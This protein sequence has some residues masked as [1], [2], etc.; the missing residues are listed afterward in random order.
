M[1][2]KLISLFMVLLESVI[3]Y[4]TEEKKRGGFYRLLGTKV[5]LKQ[6]EHLVR[7]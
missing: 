2:E 1:R 6:L 5:T 7:V 3:E 4:S